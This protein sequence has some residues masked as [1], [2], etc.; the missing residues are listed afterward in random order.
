MTYCSTAFSVIN[1]GLK[2]FGRFGKNKPTIC[3]EEIKKKLTSKTKVIMP[4]HLYGSVVD[5]NEIKKLLRIKRF[6][7]LMIVA[8]T[9]LN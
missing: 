9:V 5:I 6:I 7:L 8:I 4:V 3:I 2:P 1:A